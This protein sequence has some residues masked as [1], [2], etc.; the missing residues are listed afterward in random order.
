MTADR[1][2]AVTLEA[3]VAALLLLSS[4]VFALQMTAVTP[5]SAST[6]S[7]HIENQLE[8]SAE[9]IMAASVEDGSLRRA[10]L[11]YNE[12]STTFANSTYQGYYAGAPPES[13][14]GQRLNWAFDQRG[15]AYNVYVSYSVG[16]QD[17]ERRMIYRGQPSDNAI[18][19]TTTITLADD[20]PLYNH[21]DGDGTLEPRSLTVSNTSRFY[22]PDISNSGLYNVIRVE[23]V[24]WRI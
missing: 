3:V 6:S 12:T 21:S 24:V 13:K 14:L 18:S 2:Q 11:Y 22:A 20:A 19:T 8:A 16:G 7:Q 1:G 9:G 4:L 15:I 10:V 5:L 17:R 23:V